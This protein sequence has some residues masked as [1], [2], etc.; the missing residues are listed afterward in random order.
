MILTRDTS[1][2]YAG[3]KTCNLLFLSA[4]MDDSVPNETYASLQNQNTHPIIFFKHILVEP[5]V[6]LGKF[7]F[8]L[9]SLEDCAKS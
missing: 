1:D 2:S 4:S 6:F 9:N 5:V 7:T 8:W 3:Q